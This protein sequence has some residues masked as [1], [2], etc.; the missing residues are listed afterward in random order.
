MS[1][2]YEISRN[3]LIQVLDILEYLQDFDR[4]G[5]NTREDNSGLYRELLAVL[6]GDDE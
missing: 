1:R 3:Q 6:E 2:G 4:T 5:V